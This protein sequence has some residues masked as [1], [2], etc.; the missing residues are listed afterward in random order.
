[1]AK[2]YRTTDRIPVKIG[3]LVFKLSPLTY[4]QKI[5][6]ADAFS[7]VNGE[8]T[9]KAGTATAL[10]MKYSIKEVEGLEYATGDEPYKL[11]F[12]KDGESLTSECLNELFS[13]ECK[14]DLSMACFALLNGITDKVVNS[15][16]GEPL[17][18]I[19]ILPVEGAAVKK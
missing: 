17:E 6:V 11:K 3:D 8:A 12:E 9:Q 18:G 4:D 13:L 19:E 14:A 1:M 2:I 7:V 16:T 5:K 15:E 10:I